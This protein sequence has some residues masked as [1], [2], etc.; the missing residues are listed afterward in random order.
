[1]PETYDQ[2]QGAQGCRRQPQAAYLQENMTVKLSLPR[3]EFPCPF[4]LPQRVTL[5]VVGKPSRSPR[6]RP[7]RP[8]TKA[9]HPSPTARPHNA[10]VPPHIAVGTRVV[11]LTEDGS[12]SD[13]RPRT[14]Q[15]TSRRQFR[16]REGR[17]VGWE[18]CRRFRQSMAGQLS[19]LLLPQCMAEA[20]PP[21]SFEQPA[22]LGRSRRMACRAR[23]ASQRDRQRSPAVAANVS[24]FARAGRVPRFDP[25][26]MRRPWCN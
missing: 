3:R 2:V 15:R 13:A 20:G 7:R 6:A 22:I 10:P 23:S 12:Y 9:R 14:K 17:R 4:Q 21:K 18:S 16:R 8:P 26:A 5:E 11:V 19:F 25:R 1:M 24:F